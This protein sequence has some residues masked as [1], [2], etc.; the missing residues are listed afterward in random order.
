MCGIYGYVSLGEKLE[1]DVLSRMGETLA[2]QTLQSRHRGIVE[3]V[4]GQPVG[5]GG[6]EGDDDHRHRPFMPAPHRN[7]GDERNPE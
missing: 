3:P 6:V 1:P 5:A 2:R 4:H 7:R